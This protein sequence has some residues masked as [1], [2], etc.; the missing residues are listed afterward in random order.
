VQGIYPVNKTG[1]EWHWNTDKTGHSGRMKLP[2][3][4]PK[5]VHN[6]ST[7]VFNWKLLDTSNV[8]EMLLFLYWCVEHLIYNRNYSI[9]AVKQWIYI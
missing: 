4:H 2:C 6:T 8:L 1:S 9:P 5:Y 7:Q 3:E